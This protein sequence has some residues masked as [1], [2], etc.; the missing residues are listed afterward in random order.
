[1]NSNIIEGTIEN[2]DK[3]VI[4]SDQPVLVDFWAEWCGPCKMIA[5]ALDDI[6][7]KRQG[8][9]KVVKV[10]VDSQSELAVRFGIRSIPTL[11]VFKDGVQDKTKM[12][13]VSAGELEKWIDSD[14]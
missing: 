1:M 4:Q 8:N 14:D 9:I 2:F 10:D 12:G 7:E 6:A 5:P 11:M 13:A 3:E